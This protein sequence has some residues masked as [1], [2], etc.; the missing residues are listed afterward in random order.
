M[1]TRWWIGV[2]LGSG[3]IVS[4][5]AAFF[6]PAATAYPAVARRPVARYAD[7]LVRWAG[8]RPR[9]TT[10]W[11]VTQDLKRLRVPDAATLKCL[12]KRGTGGPDVLASARLDQLPDQRVH[13]A[14]CGN[15]MTAN[16]T[17]RRGMYLTSARG[18]YKLLLQDDGNLVL[19]A[20][21]GP[22]WSNHRF[23]TQYAIMQRDGNFAT[24]ARGNIANWSTATSGKG[25][26]RL[27][28][29]RDGNLVLYAGTKALWSSVRAE[30]RTR[31]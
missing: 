29:Q 2:V 30:R 13:W 3:L 15:R 12:R 23:D 16:R 24:Y 19:Y 17:L 26:K 28:V 5:G 14:A 7:H 1:T 25:G 27:V 21:S 31:S 4:A 20:P 9:P 6:L 8:Q 18:R 22:I 10:T 11:Y